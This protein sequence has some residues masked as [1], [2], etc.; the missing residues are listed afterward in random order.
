MMS[1][2]FRCVVYV[3]SCKITG[4]RYVGI[5]Q[6]TAEERFAAHIYCAQVGTERVLYDAMRKYGIHNF[7]VSEVCVAFSW[8]NACLIEQA[9]IKEFNSKVP[10]GYNMTDGGEGTVGW[11]APQEVRDVW[12]K[13]RKGRTWTKE[14]NDARSARVKAQWADPEFRRKR[15]QSMGNRT[16]TDD[17]RA[18]RSAAMKG[19]PGRKH[20]PETRAKIS[21][22]KQAQRALQLAEKEQME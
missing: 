8:E 10:N 2:D 20:T 15:Q 6:A 7:T 19:M 22:T 5:T 11:S 16:W 17:Q 9:L 4:K 14:Q 13:Q 1:S 12:S 18:K 3:I 21:A